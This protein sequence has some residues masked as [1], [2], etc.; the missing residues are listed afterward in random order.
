[1]TWTSPHVFSY[2]EILTSANLNGNFAQ[3]SEMAAAK[4]TAKGQVLA[5]TG[6]NAGAVVSVASVP[7]YWGLRYNTGLSMGLGYAQMRSVLNNVATPVTVV[8]SSAE[9]NLWSY[10]LAGGTL[11]ANGAL[12]FEMFVNYTNTSGSNKDLTTKFYLGSTSV[13]LTQTIATGTTAPSRIYV[14]VAPQ[15][16]TNSQVIFYAKGTTETASSASIDMTTTQTL[17]F[18]VQHSASA[19]TVSI[20]GYMPTLYLIPASS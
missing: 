18:T 4:F 17:K 10:S 13:S 7:N 12:V 6:A 9:T 5:A 8:S 11:A 14:M 15:N 3:L 16:A 19:S 20:T 2:A 1:M